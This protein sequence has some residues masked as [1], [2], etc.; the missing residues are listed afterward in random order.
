VELINY[1]AGNSSAHFKRYIQEATSSG[2]LNMPIYES[3]M[4]NLNKG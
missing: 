1:P 3:K 2:N 4:V